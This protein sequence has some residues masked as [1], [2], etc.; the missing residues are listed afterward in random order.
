[1]DRRR[2]I[3]SASLVAATAA[4]IVAESPSGHQALAQGSFLEG[5]H[6]NLPAT[7][8]NVK[9]ATARPMT[10]RWTEQRWVLDNVIQAN[11]VDWDQP[12]TSY[13]N[14]PCGMEASADFAAIRQRVKKFADI[15]TEFEAQARR[16]EQRAHA[17]EQTRDVVTARE[18]YFVAAVHWG[19][20]QWPIQE[21]N[22]QNRWYN[23]RKRECFTKYAKFADH[24][25]TPVWIPIGAKSLPAWF[26]LPV[27]YS[28][29]RIPAVVMIPGMDSFKEAS[30]A[31]Y[32]DPL[33]SRGFAVLALDGPGQ[34]ESPLLGVYMTMEGWED[35]GKACMDWLQS[36]K[37]VDPERVA[38]TGRSFGSFGATIAVSNEPRYRAIAVSATCFEPGFH[39]IFQEASPT[40]KMRFMFMA[41]IADE[42]AFDEFRKILTWEGYADKISMPYLCVAG[43]ADELSPIGNTERLFKT[44]RGPRQL[45]I[46]QESRHSVGGV[47][48]AILG[49][50]VS[51]LTSDW[52]AARFNGDS[53]TTE[54]W[55]VDSQGQITKT[56]I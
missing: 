46:Y 10:R 13:W 45:V 14:A 35:V 39:T 5:Q 7:N 43:Q 15:S 25:V 53:F 3:Q 21:A 12:R 33:L 1:M 52:L 56:Q 40:F 29:G 8:E 20:A 18:N 23:R 55:F 22:E 50:S 38:M 24:P 34:Y 27:G 26:H 41:N 11:G 16:R 36:Q 31:L 28:A 44:L 37:E 2:F 30:V 48:S 49:P 32:G 19:A 51:M 54:Q 47:P 6:D 17:A 9:G 42:A 4:S